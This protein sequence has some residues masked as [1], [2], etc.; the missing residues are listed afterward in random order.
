MTANAGDAR[1][2]RYR[3]R[4]DSQRAVPASTHPI[5]IASI[6]VGNVSPM[7]SRAWG[8]STQTATLH[9]GASATAP[10]ASHRLR[11]SPSR[12]IAIGHST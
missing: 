8:H 10:A 7:P 5:A 3:V 4:A 12:A 1:K 2:R 9:S 11:R 6:T